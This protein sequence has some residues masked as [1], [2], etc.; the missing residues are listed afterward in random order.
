MPANRGST[1]AL[2][3]IKEVTYGTT[4]STPTLFEIPI[5][6]YTPRHS[7]EALRSDQKRAH[8]FLDRLLAGRAM[9]EIGVEFELQA[10][11]HDL[12]LETVFGSVIASKAMKYLDVL[13]GM[14]LEDRVGGGSSLF[15]QFSGSYFNRLEVAC[16]ANDT[17]PVK[18]TVAG[19]ARVGTLDA[20]ATLATAVTAA[21]DNDPYSF[22]DSDLTIAGTSYPVVSG[23][24]VLERQVDPLKL[25]GNQAPRE[26]V[27]GAV[28][29]SGTIVI[30]YDDAS[31]STLW[32]AFANSAL[33]YN[34]GAPAAATFRKFTF[35]RTR[36]TT[37]GRPYQGRGVVLQELG[38]EALYSPSDTT[39]CTLTT[40]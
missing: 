21:A 10:A 35:H 7:H 36:P 40:Q 32:S 8:P 3:G 6:T 19:M 30:P 12:I 2:Y 13:K 18:C 38:W 16:S 28:A 15:N 9:H 17:T 1:Q 31:V 25:W 5:N 39:I 29:G 11:N 26:Y 4:P 23:S 14:T 20:G 33:V 34:L 27:P 37:L 22:I 24:F